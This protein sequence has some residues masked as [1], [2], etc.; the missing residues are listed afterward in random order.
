MNAIDN[1]P[2]AIG[3]ARNGQRPADDGEQS[4]DRKGLKKE[5]A[6]GLERGEDEYHERQHGGQHREQ[7]VAALVV[8]LLQF[9][10]AVAPITTPSANPRTHLKFACAGDRSRSLSAPPEQWLHRAGR[11]APARCRCG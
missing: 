1:N 2:N 7:P 9:A 6:C 4:R 10:Q 5:D 11:L 8:Q 3:F